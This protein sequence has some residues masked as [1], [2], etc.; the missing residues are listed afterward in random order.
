M[1]KLINVVGKVNSGAATKR[2]CKALADEY[3]A[4][5]K[6]GPT[7]GTVKVLAAALDAI[8]V[9]DKDAFLAGCSITVGDTICLPFKVGAAGKYPYPAQVAIVAHECEHVRQG[10]D[11]WMTFWIRYFTSKAHRAA[12]EAAALAA[13]LEVYYRL[14][15]RMLDVKGLA[16]G[17]EWYKV[18]KTDIAVTAKHLAIVRDTLLRGGE[19]SDQMKVIAKVLS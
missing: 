8:G 5:I 17:L 1:T 9:S 10:N 11:E 14:T 13:E 4:D 15:G 18:G 12:Y 19:V 16:K 3:G 6:Y 2:V 7:S